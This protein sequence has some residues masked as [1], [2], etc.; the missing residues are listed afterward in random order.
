MYSL[1]TSSPFFPLYLCLLKFVQ[2]SPTIFAVYVKAFF[3]FPALLSRCCLGFA[4]GTSQRLFQHEVSTTNPNFK[5]SS[6]L[7]L[8]LANVLI[9]MSNSFINSLEKM[10]IFTNKVAEERSRTDFRVE[11][12][13]LNLLTFLNKNYPKK[14]S[15][16]LLPNSVNNHKRWV[17]V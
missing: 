9:P 10:Q 17:S 8:N 15:L 7:H 5:R 11:Q 1:D 6:H 13:R 14:I 3:C 12:D 2:I 16:F 4:T